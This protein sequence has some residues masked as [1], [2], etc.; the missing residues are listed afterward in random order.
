MVNGGGGEDVLAGF[1]GPF[2]VIGGDAL[3]GEVSNCVSAEDGGEAAFGGGRVIGGG[4]GGEGEGVGE[5]LG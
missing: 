2:V 1:E 3:E 5:E 4:G